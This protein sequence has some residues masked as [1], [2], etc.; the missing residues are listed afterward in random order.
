MAKKEKNGIKLRTERS[1]QVKKVDNKMLLAR[2][3]VAGQH[4]FTLGQTT[5]SRLWQKMMPYLKGAGF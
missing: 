3:Q 4:L 2:R 1:V 5:L